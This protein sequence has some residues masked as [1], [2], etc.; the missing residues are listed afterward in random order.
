VLSKDELIVFGV[1]YFIEPYIYGSVD[2]YGYYVVANDGVLYWNNPA[3][4][5]QNEG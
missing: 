3:V 4:I 2:C 1:V 5:N